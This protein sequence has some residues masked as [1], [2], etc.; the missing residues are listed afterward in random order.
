MIA[1]WVV[2]HNDGGYKVTDLVEESGRIIARVEGFGYANYPCAINAKTGVKERG[3]A[4]HKAIKLEAFAWA[5]RVAGLYPV[6]PE[7]ARPPFYT[8][9]KIHPFRLPE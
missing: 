1:E 9:N 4:Y 7:D 6:H 5:E 2:V 8:V 3:G